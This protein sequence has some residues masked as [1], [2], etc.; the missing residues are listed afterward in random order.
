MSKQRAPTVT[1]QDVE[2][3]LRRDFA[4]DE[5]E[6]RALLMSYG[7]EDWHRETRRVR[8]AALKLANGDLARLRV[9]VDTAKADY[10]DVLGPAEYPQYLKAVTPAASLSDEE[11]QRIIEADFEQYDGWFRR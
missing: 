5:E 11:R 8:V 9:A 4:E 2:R 10:R 3:I 1:D 7:S 6:A